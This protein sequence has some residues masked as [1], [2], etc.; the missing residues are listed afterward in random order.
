V[1]NI[2][3]ALAKP[4]WVAELKMSD[5]ISNNP[6]ENDPR[7]LRLS[8]EDNVVVLIAA[9]EAGETVQIQGHLVEIPERLPLG[10][11]LAA[12]AIEPGEKII[13]YGV[14]IGSATQ[15]IPVGSLVHTHNLKS[16]YLPT[17]PQRQ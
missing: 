9:L 8:P 2:F 11:K 3:S 1:A 4:A 5:E 7:L 12:R 13:K 17:R 6:P 14:P 15:P 10:F 16:D